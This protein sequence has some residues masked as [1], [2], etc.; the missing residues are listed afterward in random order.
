MTFA[1]GRR[2]RDDLP[3]QRHKGGC[4][5]RKQTGAAGSPGSA[6]AVPERKRAC[7]RNRR[8]SR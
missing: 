6:R 4:Q 3:L 7:W 1:A 2:N 5:Q 8:K